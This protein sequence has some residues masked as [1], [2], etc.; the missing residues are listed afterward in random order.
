MSADH[1]P[2]VT[3]KVVDMKRADFERRVAGLGYS[4][5]PDTRPGREGGYWSSH[6]NLMWETW[7]AAH[8]RCAALCEQEHHESGEHP[9][10]ALH[11]RDRILGVRPERS[12]QPVKEQNTTEARTSSTTAKTV[13]TTARSATA[14]KP[15]YL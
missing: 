11:C 1:L 12:H 3:E 5:D 15:R 13:C 2:D 4:V 6:T 8:L 14:L 10:M 9:E 7:L